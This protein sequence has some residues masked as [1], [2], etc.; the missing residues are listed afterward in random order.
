VNALSWIFHVR[1]IFWGLA[2][3]TLLLPRAS[4]REF[5]E[6]HYKALLAVVVGS[7]ALLFAAAKESQL[8]ALAL[9]SQDFW[10]FEDMLEQMKKGAFL[11]TRFAPQGIGW[12][13]HGG[14]HATL[15]WI[16]NLPFA[17]ILSPLQVSILFEPVSFAL[18]ATLLASIVRRRWNAPAAIIL[19]SAFLM[20]SQVGK[21][22]MYDVHPEADYPFFVF[23]WAWAID[24]GASPFGASLK[25]EK[26]SRVLWIPMIIAVL[27]GLGIK[28]DAF[29]VFFPLILWIAFKGQPWQK[30]PA[31]LSFALAVGTYAFQIFA[32]GHWASGAWGP[33]TW[34]S[35][36]VILP[37]GPQVLHGLHF[38]SVSNS[39]QILSSLVADHGGWFGAIGSCFKFLISRPWLSLLVLAPWVVFQYGFWVT[40][41]PLCAAFS[42]LP[43][44]ATLP[45]YHSAIFLGTFWLWAA[46]SVRT[47]SKLRWILFAVLI[48]GAGGPEFYFSNFRAREIKT[49]T[50]R[51]LA[52]LQGQL[53][54]PAQ[55]L[56]SS[57]LISLT[58]RDMIF[59]DRIPDQEKPSIQFALL[60]PLLDNYE[61][62]HEAAQQEIERFK[63]NSNWTQLEP[64]LQEV[65]IWVKRAR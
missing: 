41:L 50:T 62:S 4:F 57:T 2:P 31:L 15:T 10:L 22:L 7:F 33:S 37:A 11:V 29:L 24:F 34:N 42:L 51:A 35:Q 38:N 40:I 47:W 43:F 21:C 6:R 39:I 27:G 54:D 61:M 25:D 26:S 30:K 32:L 12:V 17:Y 9:N 5:S 44:A 18:S 16:W 20:S 49:E 23:L 48:F 59:T 56:V 60:T 13:Q 45:L 55:G 28:E 14:V 53:S 52:A 19:A 3:L 36:P 64:G 8:H 46:L 63:Q 58:P 65:S 1:W